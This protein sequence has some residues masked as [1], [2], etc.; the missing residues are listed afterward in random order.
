MSEKETNLNNISYIKDRLSSGTYSQIN[1]MLNSL[2]PSDI[3]HFIESSPPEDRDFVW[4][5]LNTD[6]EGEVLNHLSDA[7]QE[8]FLKNMDAAEVAEVTESLETDE[9]A[10]IIQRM[11]EA[12]IEEV[13]SSMSIQNRVRLE[14]VLSYPEDSAGGMMN[15]DVIAVRKN[16]TL[17]VVMRYLRMQGSIPKSTNKIFV[18]NRE[19]NYRGSLNLN[20]LLISD[21]SLHVEDI[22]EENDMAI[23]ISMDDTE[24]ARTFEKKDLI[25]APVIDDQG[26]LVGRITIDDVVDVIKEDADESFRQISGL[27]QDT[28]VK[29]SVATKSRAVWLGLNLITAFI[30]A[31]FIDIFKDTIAEVVTLA[32]LMPIVASMGGVAATQTLTIMVRGMALGQI[33]RTNILWLIKRETLVG[34]GNGILWAIVVGLITSW[35]FQD[36]LIAQIIAFAMILNLLVGVLSGVFIPLLL[37]SINL[38]PGVGGTVIVTTITDVAGFVSFLGLA[39]IFLI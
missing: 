22:Y 36:T 8:Q 31:S 25:S 15:T 7:L 6:I 35:W 10:D 28:F 11:P 38:D 20:K 9:I 4:Q 2:N 18:V 23:S 39:T 14:E 34:L 21:L 12:V 24:V 37:K 32:V 3:A 30:A 16:H 17:D 5:I 26:K 13:L 33:G 27:E 19:N 1:R 29:T